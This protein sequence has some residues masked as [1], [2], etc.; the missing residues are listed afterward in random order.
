M[1]YE[2]DPNQFASVA[3]SDSEAIAL[4]I[5]AA[6][7]TGLNKVRIP[8]R[9]ERTGADVWTVDTAI[10]LPSDIEILL[11]NCTL[12]QAD[13]CFDNIFRTLHTHT[14][15]AAS[16]SSRLKNIHITGLGSAT[17]DGGCH[18]GL[19]ERTSGK[20]GMPHV[21]WN[22]MILMTNVEAFSIT[23]ITFRDMRWW[24]VNLIFASEGKLQSLTFDA[25]DNVPNQDGLDLRVGCHNI[26]VENIYGR[27]GDD[28]VALSG[29]CGFERR[30]GFWVTGMSPDIHHI[31]IRNVIGS[32]ITKGVIALRNQDGICLHDIDIDGVHDTSEDGK[33]R[34]YAVVRI[35][36]KTY[37]SIR[38][39]EL[40]ETSRIAVRNIHATVGDA[41]MVNVTLEN[42]I[43]ENIFLGKGAGSAFT[44]R[45]DWKAPGASLRAVLI[46]GV[47]CAPGSETLAPVIDLVAETEDETLC[48]VRI[49]DVFAEAGRP[50]LKS[51]Y[52]TAPMTDFTE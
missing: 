49:T 23:G 8:R 36:Q 31:T 40:S 52:I 20:D 27:A 43:F 41:V 16:P 32:S 45:S 19:T 42:A 24:A 46:R 28:L 11:D 34:P 15:A 25:R 21:I 17:L 18:N 9:N 6:K 51:N 44:T 35:G 33:S 39:S 1:L 13:G 4:A 47:F 7:D 50:L 48:D 2:I 5:R 37:G 29:F 12:R 3:R 38:F 14:A 30:A 26:T 10:L 22:N